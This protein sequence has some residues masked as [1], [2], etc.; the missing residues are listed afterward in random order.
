MART[1]FQMATQAALEDEDGNELPP[2]E[3]VYD[4][5]FGFG[6]FTLEC[7]LPRPA[8]VINF[9][10]DLYNG[11]MGAIAAC[12]HLLA[13]VSR[14]GHVQ[15]M[16]MMVEN[17][18]ITIGAIYGGDDVNPE[19]VVDILLERQSANPTRVSSGSSP[20]ST[21]AGRRSTGRSPGANSTRSR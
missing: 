12:Y 7:R 9:Y 15:V 8:E 18:L 10:A 1:E 16:K 21:A 20:S 4:Q 19:G 3:I 2:E 13:R 5:Q 17:E 6:D 14:P 11:G